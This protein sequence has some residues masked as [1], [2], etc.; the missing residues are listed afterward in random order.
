MIQTY[1]IFIYFERSVFLK[2]EKFLFSCF[3]NQPVEKAV[4]QG[5][6]GKE[7]FSTC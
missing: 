1:V 7:S 3:S 6:E 5:F 2:V 4:T